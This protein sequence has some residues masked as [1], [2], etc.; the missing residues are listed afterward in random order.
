MQVTRTFHPPAGINQLLVVVHG[1]PWTFLLVPVGAGAALL[2]LFV[3]GWHS[4]V[5]GRPWP[6]RWW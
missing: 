5:R 6:T 2:A 1:L 4:V 3:F